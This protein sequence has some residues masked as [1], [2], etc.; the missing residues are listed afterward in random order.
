MGD[1]A[2]FFGC[3]CVSTSSSEGIMPH[4]L[5]VEDMVLMITTL[6]LILQCEQECKLWNECLVLEIPCSKSQASTHH[7]GF[8]NRPQWSFK[9]NG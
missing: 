5:I 1:N 4:H 6:T 2:T 7:V 9:W 8:K 3:W